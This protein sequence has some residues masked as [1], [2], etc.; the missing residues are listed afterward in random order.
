MIIVEKYGGSSVSDITKIKQIATHIAIEVKKKNKLVVVFSAMGKTTNKLL[1]MVQE[2]DKNLS[3][4]E[5]D[6][7]LAI[8]EIKSI[9]LG[10]L[11]LKK[12]GIKTISLNAY[13]SGIITNGRFQNALIEEID[14]EKLKNYLNK[15]DVLLIA[16]FQ[17]VAN[18]EF[19]TIGRGGSD[20][21]AVALASVLKAP[22]KIYTD[23]EYVYQADPRFVSK[24]RAFKYISYEQMLEM[25]SKGAG[26][27]STRCVAL[28]K[29]QLVDLSLHKSLCEEGTRVVD[30][31]ILEDDS[32]DGLAI[33][34]KLCY[35]KMTDIC[36]KELVKKLE[37]NDIKA[38]MFTLDNY[39]IK[40]VIG[41]DD[42]NRFESLFNK[43]KYEIDMEL[44]RVS[45]I[46]NGLLCK[47]NKLL[48][49][50]EILDY[51]QIFPILLTS[52]EIT[53]SF[54]VPKSKLNKVINKIAQEFSL[55][56]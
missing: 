10:A 50:L 15:Y 30:G 14:Q 39:L 38:D 51:E 44:S 26:V 33:N 45:L 29:K 23:V 7:L 47:E 31:E 21:T 25:S 19:T 4:R 8:G 46:G 5:I 52:S 42:L 49:I 35:V 56:S 2:I 24:P 28:A 54:L 12:M 16:G 34:E 20:T 53:I 27:L 1:S 43:K 17:G 9:A 41:I 11:A 3:G 55:A 32:I 37:E 36:V 18:N 13:Q 48:K 40:F 6:Q 22:C